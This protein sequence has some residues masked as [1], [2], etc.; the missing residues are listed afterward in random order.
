MRRVLELGAGR[1]ADFEVLDR[2][3]MGRSSVGGRDGTMTTFPQILP[4]DGRTGEE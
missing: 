2:V 4:Y 1:H 3:T